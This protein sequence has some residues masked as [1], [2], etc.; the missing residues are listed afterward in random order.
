MG[1]TRLQDEE[2]EGLIPWGHRHKTELIRK[3][4]VGPGVRGFNVFI[5]ARGREFARGRRQKKAHPEKVKT[6]KSKGERVEDQPD[7][8][9]GNFLG[10]I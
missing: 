10:K 7:R 2:G 4:K 3:G 5:H 8:T 6:Y 1:W 9:G